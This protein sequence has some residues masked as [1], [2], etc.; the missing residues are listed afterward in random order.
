MKS[1]WQ[2]ENLEVV[3]GIILIDPSQWTSQQMRFL[4]MGIAH[5]PRKCRDLPIFIMFG[6]DGIKKEN[7]ESSD[8]VEV[9]YSILLWDVS[10][11]A[12]DIR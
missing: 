10:R 7:G 5:S 9:V 6:R 2:G 4:L 8:V 1:A 11:L 12:L 3:L